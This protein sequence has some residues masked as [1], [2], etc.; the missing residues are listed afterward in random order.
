MSDEKSDGARHNPFGHVWPVAPALEFRTYFE[1]MMKDFS[2]SPPALQRRST[3]RRAVFV[4]VVAVFLFGIGVFGFLV[5]RSYLVIRSSIDLAQ[6]S[7]RKTITPSDRAAT[8]G[9]GSPPHIETAD[10]PKLGS[11][12]AKVSIVEFGDFEC[13]FCRQSFVILKDLLA[14]YGNK[15]RFQFRDFPNTSIH[16][17]AM[18]SALAARCANEQGRFWEYHDLLYINQE[19]LLDE[20]LATYATQIG[21][22]RAAFDE[23]FAT[24]RYA[25][26]VRADA[27]DGEALGVEG[28]PTWF[29]NG[30][31]VEGVI[32]FD[33]FEKIVKYGLKGKL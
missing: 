20:D 17:R 12:T 30:R 1:S 19:R 27:A 5:V 9:V 23:C 29:I 8:N 4:G 25:A 31:R 14:K 10:D 21:L 11:D 18:A 2:S 22:D 3:K 26:D 32:P 15:I 6:Y 33:V 28:T 13:P 7:D 16:P 24:Q